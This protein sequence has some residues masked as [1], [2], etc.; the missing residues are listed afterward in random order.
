MEVGMDRE[1]HS[2]RARKAG[3]ILLVAFVR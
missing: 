1:D 2:A 3:F